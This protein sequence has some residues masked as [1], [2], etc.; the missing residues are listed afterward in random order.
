L[1][2]EIFV[3]EGEIYV[4]NEEIC[5]LEEEILFILDGKTDEEDGEGLNKNG[6]LKEDKEEILEKD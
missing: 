2:E 5:G 1:G 4:C 6:E 3:S